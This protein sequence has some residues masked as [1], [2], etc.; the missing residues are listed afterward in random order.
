[1]E[2]LATRRTEQGAYQYEIAPGRWVSRQRLHQIREQVK[3]DARR[4]VT[5][6]LRKGL[7]TRSP[8][9]VCGS[10]TVQAHHDDY[11][12]PL[13]VHWLCRRHHQDLHRPPQ[14][15]QAPAPSPDPA[16]VSAAAVTLGRRGGKVKS[17]AKTAAAQAN[18][19]LGGRRK[20]PT[21]GR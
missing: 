6:A 10:G 15:V 18:G 4:A 3:H 16:L 5:V 1:M 13:N 9:E 14:Y 2:V 7:L 11:S 12:I 19:K 8:C 21:V 17:P 20:Q